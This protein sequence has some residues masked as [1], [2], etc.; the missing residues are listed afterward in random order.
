MRA[1]LAL[2]VL[3]LVLRLG[4]LFFIPR[5]VIP[6]NPQWETGAV[7]ISLATRGEMPDPYLIPTGPTA[8][9]A[10]LYVAGMSLI[11]R[12][13]GT[14]FL[15]GLVRWILVMVA[16]S[17]L[18]ALMP[19]MGESLGVGRKAGML[20]GLMG[21]LFLTFPSEVDSYSALVLALLAMVFLLRWKKIPQS[22]G[23]YVGSFLHGLAAGVAFH[24]Q[25][26]F[27]PVVLGYMVFELWSWR[28]ER[29]WGLVG[30]MALGMLVACTPWGIRN[31]VRFHQLFFVR[32]NLGLELYV[33][34]HEGAHADIDVSAARGSFRHPRTDLAEAERVSEMGEGP[35]MKEKQREALDWIRTRP[36]EFLKLTA[37]RFFYFWAGPVHDPSGAAP[38]LI[39]T[40]LALLGAWRILPLL[41]TTQ[42]VVLFIPLGTYPLVYYLVAYMPRYGEP[43]RWVLFLLAAVAVLGPG[44]AQGGLAE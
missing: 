12:V 42:R 15:G 24:L 25:P 14:G 4:T 1:F 28:R 34:N 19:R 20:G 23:G 9:M 7:S 35:Y 27:L 22:G 6:P 41:D 11:Y 2:F 3:S 44:R 29:R 33:G 5:D 40:V 17:I 39:L 10:P 43:I 16:C 13:L 30:L 37:T 32:S 38:Y 26:V 31:Y 21:T 36:G 18:W 8:H